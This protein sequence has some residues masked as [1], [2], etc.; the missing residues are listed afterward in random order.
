M[1]HLDRLELHSGILTTELREA[2]FDMVVVK[3]DDVA[4]DV[5]AFTLQEAHDGALPPWEPGA[6]IDLLVPGVGP[7]QYSLCGDPSDRR[8]WRVGVLNEP[9]GRG[10]SHHLYENLTDGSTIRVRGP[11]NHFRLL[12][13]EDYLFIAG[14]IGIT[15]ILPM[16]AAAERA[17]A[18]WR[19]VYG[20]RRLSSMGFLDELASYG[21]RVTVSPQDEKGLIDVVGVL[22]SASAGTQVYC[23]G[24]AGHCSVRSSTSTVTVHP[25]G[26][27][28]S[29]SNLGPPPSRIGISPSS[30]SSG[31]QASL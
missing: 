30:S 8:L 21:D 12:P 17:G 29:G 18:N 9:D 26:C 24:P 22:G 11:R 5:V 15:P 25:G 6:H 3:R 16:V 13:A 7:R 27:T 10:G 20:G 4:E 14:G 28:S 2:E 1:T 23:C 19:L 31:H